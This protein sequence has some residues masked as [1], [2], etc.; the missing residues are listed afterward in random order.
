MSNLPPDRNSRMRSDPE[1]S[2]H[3]FLKSLIIVTFACGVI[4]SANSTTISP[5]APLAAI[6]AD[7]GVTAPRID[8]LASESPAETAEIAEAPPALL[9]EGAARYFRQLIEL[10]SKGPEDSSAQD[11][12]AQDPQD[13]DPQ[14][15]D[16]V[17]PVPVTPVPVDPAGDPAVEDADP[18]APTEGRS[19]RSRQGDTQRRRRG[20][21]QGGRQDRT[22]PATDPEGQSADETGHETAQDG[23]SGSAR[24]DRSRR[25][26][27]DEE[28]GARR[29]KVPREGI[30]V[31]HPLIE[32]R[33]VVCHARDDEGKMTR[34]SYM[35][36]TPEAWEI[37]IKRMA[38]LYFVSLSSEEAKEVVRYLAEEHGL[39]RQEARAAMYES[40][41]RVHWSEE[42]RDKDLRETC[43]ECH[44]LGRV[45]SERRDE[46]EWKLLK[47][48]HLALYPLV[49]FQS[50]RGRSSRGG[51]GRGATSGNAGGG[52]GTPSSETAGTSGRGR[53][54]DR[55][56]RVLATLTSEQGL[57]SDEWRDWNQEKREVPLEG[58]WIV[59]GHEVGRG[60]IRGTLDLQ[61]VASGEY[62][63]K[64]TWL[65]ANGRTVV[66]Q[67]TGLF[68]AGHSWRGRST[69]TAPGELESLK[70]VLL[71]DESW[72]RM[73][74]RLF[75]GEYNELGIEVQLLRASETPTI[76]GVLGG[77][78]AVPSIGN[79]I[80]VIGSGFPEKIVAG[81]FHLGAGITVLGVERHDESRVNLLVSVDAGVPLGRRAIDFR[82]HQGPR[83]I[84]LYDTIDGI[85]I[86][87]NPGFSR[88]GG[89]MRPKQLERFEAV[90]FTRGPDGVPYNEDD[91]E[92]M[93]VPVQ[94]SLEEFPIRP[95][96]D[97]LQFVGELD[98]ETG[99][100]TPA[101]DG[102]N[103]ERRFSANNIGDVYVV[104]TCTM[105]VPER[106]EVKKVPDDE[107]QSGDDDGEGATDEVA[108]AEQSTDQGSADAAKKPIAAAD[109]PP[110]M[111]EREF[112][113]RG[114]LLVTVPIYVQWDQNKWNQR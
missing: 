110:K 82:I 93:T 61:R 11:P 95:G 56:D 63:S 99:V 48:T 15:P 78:M 49:D 5:A 94:W 51:G 58:R 114:H 13:E 112:R 7:D 74:G 53:S 89:K 64:W 44:T 106:V 81:D 34:I 72:T 30:P 2:A 23:E 47:A 79:R 20:G 68:Y 87:P 84:T 42:D 101:I 37:S 71:L 100:F 35:R 28:S 108:G 55:A 98:S 88:V 109:S 6:S 70:E 40:E 65:R 97:D 90:A 26:D 22:A 12:S 92:L 111:I 24:G 80:E 96:D 105:T 19:R 69:S 43:A 9:P 8:P 18:P 36:K 103:P 10:G 86:R 25:G 17:T 21:R 54:Q 66:R 91:V 29:K 14:D 73:E 60:P 46:Q 67:G 32:E 16:P 62:Q 4:Y 102:P 113:A 104:A 38:R 3:W 52:G 50:F 77:E 33:C 41:R 83:A 85:R 76:L 39:S 107:E 45:L 1:H 59:L 31:Q 27:S 75:T 57:F